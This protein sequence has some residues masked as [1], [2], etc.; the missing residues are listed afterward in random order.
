MGVE[1]VGG[2]EVVR[3][4]GDY[5]DHR[6]LAPGLPRSRI[7][8][9]RVGEQAKLTPLLLQHPARLLLLPGQLQGL[10]V[11]LTVRG[12]RGGALARGELLARRILAEHLLHEA[13]VGSVAGRRQRR[14]LQ[15]EPLRTRFEVA[16][17]LPHPSRDGVG[18]REQAANGGLR[19]PPVSPEPR[20]GLERLGSGLLA[21]EALVDA[22]HDG[23]ELLQRGVV[24]LHL[25]SRG[26]LPAAPGGL[27]RRPGRRVGEGEPG[28]RAALH[29]APVLEAHVH[30][31]LRAKLH[32]DTSTGAFAN[33]GADAR[34]GHSTADARTSRLYGSAPVLFLHD[35]LILEVPVDTAHEAAHRLSEVMISGMREVVP[36]VKVSTEF[37]IASRWYKGAKPV[38][39]NGRLAP[40]EPKKKSS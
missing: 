32:D 5:G 11:V 29:D 34:A 39:V 36:D 13:G 21:D 30:H 37:A 27:L 1:G 20:G 35:E 25:R 12:A 28:R 18:L 4:P 26:R 17:P 2:F 10:L 31:A 14:P 6:T 24:D 9:P 7:R 16:V 3:V 15:G 33:T 40:W 23:T 22:L 8:L 38:F 19:E